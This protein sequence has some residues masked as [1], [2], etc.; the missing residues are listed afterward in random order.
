M[1]KPLGDVATRV[2]FETTTTWH[3]NFVELAA[4]ECVDTFLTR[5]LGDVEDGTGVVDVSLVSALADPAVQ[6]ALEAARTQLLT[7]GACRSPVRRAPAAPR[8]RSGAAWRRPRR[9]TTSSRA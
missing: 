2:L 1:S 6:A 4:T 7:A 9:R 5:L 8:R 3:D